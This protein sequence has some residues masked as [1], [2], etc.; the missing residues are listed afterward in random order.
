MVNK[1]KIIAAAGIVALV[2]IVGLYFYFSTNNKEAKSI[3]TTNTQPSSPEAV[4]S[5]QLK[6]YTDSSGFSFSYPADLELQKADEMDNS[7]YS[8]LTIASVDVD[9]SLAIKVTDTKLATLDAWVKSSSE[10]SAKITKTKL[11]SLEA[12]E[13]SSVTKTTLAAIDQGVLFLITVSHPEQQSYWQ[14]IYKS[15]SS[16]FAFAAPQASTASLDQA[17]D[18]GVD[19]EGE[20]VIE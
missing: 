12:V 19:F 7:I 9:G 18:S 2:V 16:S 1:T 11:G 13:V 8:D 20:E 6:Q 17:V 10:P 4:P 5:K 14:N 3:I 15:V